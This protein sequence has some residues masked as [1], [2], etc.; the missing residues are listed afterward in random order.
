[1]TG[2][3]SAT[4]LCGEGRNPTR[5]VRGCS[6]RT[7]ERETWW[8]PDVREELRRFDKLINRCRRGELTE[9]EFEFYSTLLETEP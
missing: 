2:G 7:P 9:E 6:L 3:M 4:H 5:D 1:M 8:S